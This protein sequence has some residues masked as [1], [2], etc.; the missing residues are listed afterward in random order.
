MRNKIRIVT[1]IILLFSLLLLPLPLTAINGVN[2]EQTPENQIP[3]TKYR[4]AYCETEPWI[5]YAGTLYGLIKGL[6]KAGWITDTSGLNYQEGQLD[7]KAMWEWLSTGNVSHQLE[8]VRDGHYSL[9]N[10]SEA[11]QEALISR[12]QQQNDIDLVISMGTAAGVLLASD[13][14]S[15]PVMVFSTSNAVRSGIIKSEED[16]GSDHIW[17]HMDARVYKRQMTVFYDLFNF[18]HLGMVYENS[19]LGR[20]YAAVDDAEDLAR[21]YGFEITAMPIVEP[22]NEA[23]QERYYRDLLSIHRQLAEKV[24]ALY[25]TMAPIDPARLS[26]LLQPFYE[27][28]IPVFSQLGTE[29]VMAGALI[30]VARADFS[31]V[32]E[33]GANNM[34]KILQGTSPRKLPQVHENIPHIAL[35]M[36]VARK[37]G[38]K[39]PFEILLVADEIY[40]SINKAAQ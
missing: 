36:E 4:V 20:V 40:Q 3:V 27:K 18:K 30:S 31:G 8:F 5:N 17:A 38:Y 2:K 25:L 9:S 13:R 15:V 34:I 23:D 37:I 24:D 33:F 16:S 19:S 35:N 28:K 10:M 26:E 7:T 29:E 1:C 21:E 6:E 11:D 14:H 12:L 32:G 39:A 22:V